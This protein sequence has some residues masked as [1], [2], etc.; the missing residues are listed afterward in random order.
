V[1]NERNDI[2][3]GGFKMS[4]SQRTCGPNLIF[5]VLAVRTYLDQPIKIVNTR[6]Y[7]HGTML[8]ST[9]LGK[10]GDCVAKYEGMNAPVQVPSRVSDSTG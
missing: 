6:A 3:V 7:H 10:L 9:E 2:C 4:M 5:R 1:V 8:I